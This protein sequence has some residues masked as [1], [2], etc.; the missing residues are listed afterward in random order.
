MIEL[1]ESPLGSAIIG[2]APLTQNQKITCWVLGALSLAVYPAM[3]QIPVAKFASLEKF[4]D[5]EEEETMGGKFLNRINE[6]VI[7]LRNTLM[8]FGIQN[9]DMEAL[10]P[11][12]GES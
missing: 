9:E 2:T 10:A 8:N 3:K 1:A 7:E 4:L 5:L 12:D 11:K 6:K